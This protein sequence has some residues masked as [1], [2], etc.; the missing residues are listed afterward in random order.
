MRRAKTIA[1][2]ESARLY[3]V[4]TISHNCNYPVLPLKRWAEKSNKEMSWLHVGKPE[5]LNINSLA[6][7]AGICPSR[8]M[9]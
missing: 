1:R 9:T 3:E 2:R 5:G 4:S 7:L 6:V 8:K